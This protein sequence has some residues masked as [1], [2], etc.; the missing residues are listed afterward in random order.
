M[1]QSDIFRINW[2]LV[3]FRVK[4]NKMEHFFTVKSCNSKGLQRGVKGVSPLHPSISLHILH[5]VLYTF[6]MALTKRI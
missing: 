5:S 4:C 2:L 3:T 6:L 1:I